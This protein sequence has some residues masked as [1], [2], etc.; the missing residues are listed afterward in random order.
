MA[1][2]PPSAAPESVAMPPRAFKVHDLWLSGEAN[3]DLSLLQRDIANTLS[4]QNSAVNWHAIAEGSSPPGNAARGKKE[5]FP[6][7]SG[8]SPRSISEYTNIF[9]L[10]CVES[11]KSE[12]PSRRQAAWVL[13]GLVLI[14]ACVNVYV[15]SRPGSRAVPVIQLAKPAAPARPAA[16][17]PDPP[18][19]PLQTLVVAPETCAWGAA[20]VSE[21]EYQARGQAMAR[22]RERAALA[23]N[24]GSLETE[25]TAKLARDR[26]SSTAEEFGRLEACLAADVVPRLAALKRLGTDKVSRRSGRA[27]K[28]V[29]W[30]DAAA[31]PAGADE[32]AAAPALEPSPEPAAQQ[33][34]GS[35]RVSRGV[36]GRWAQLKTCA[37]W[38]QKQEADLVSSLRFSWTVNGDGSVANLAAWLGSAEAPALAECA[39]GVIRRINFGASDEGQCRA[40]ISLLFNSG[41]LSRGSGE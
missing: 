22:T 3:P 21:L 34:C 15:V 30:S 27:A 13:A 18:Q 35:S 17:V 37:N 1:K 23:K 9:A 10:A 33:A 32:P 11:A 36:N 16:V 12:P 24:V 39:G 5:S 25:L 38:Q 2:H 6:A 40:E 8:I 14:A 19:L 41:E 28:G 4:Q 29:A 31:E 7:N 26:S 20:R